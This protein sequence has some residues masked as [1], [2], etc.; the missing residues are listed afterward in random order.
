[1]NVL[2]TGGAGFIGSHAALRLVEGGHAVTIADNLSRGHRAA[3]RIIGHLGDVLFVESEVGDSLTLARVMRE[4]NIDVVMHFAAMAYVGESVQQ[5][6]RYY[7][8]NTAASLG[9]LEAMESAGVARIVFSSTCATYGEPP[10]SLV[11]IAE[12]CPQQPINPYGRSKLMVE[13]M[14]RD[15]SAMKRARGED[16]AFAALRYFNV[17]GSDARGRL[18]EDHRPET[19]LIPIC[20]EAALG[21]RPHVE[22]FGCDYATPDGTCIRDYVHVED[23]VDAHVAVMNRLKPGDE[24]AFNLGI[25]RGYSV[26]EVVEACRRVTGIDFPTVESPRRPGDPPTLFANP[27]KIAR[28]LGWSA[29]YKGLDDIIETAWQWRKKHPRGYED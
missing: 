6:L 12:S 5:P 19:H 23:L 2:V 10:P 29:R 16:F 17:A 25:G 14:L 21:Q 20:L 8:Q 28:E 4:R 27:G 1:M 7:R 24:L 9:L 26:R 13:H 22:V 15:H 3:A 18:G 11:P